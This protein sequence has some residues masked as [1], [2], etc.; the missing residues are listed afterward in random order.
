MRRSVLYSRE[1]AHFLS[2]RE[3]Q[4]TPHERQKVDVILSQLGG[5]DSIL[6]IGCGS[7]QILKEVVKRVRYVVGV[8]ESADRLQD[9]ARVCRGAELIRA[10]ANELDFRERFDAVI[11]SQM[12]HEVKM[13]GRPEE[14]NEILLVI[15]RALKPEGRYLLLDHLDPGEGSVRIRVPGDTEALLLEFKSRFRYRPVLLRKLCEGRY[16]IN[17][18]DIQDFLTKTWSL[19]SPME[20]MEMNET[21]ASFSREEAETMVEG[22]GLSVDTF[23]PFTNIEGDFRVHHAT[24]EPPA[25]PWERKF[26]LVAVK[27]A[28]QEPPAVNGGCLHGR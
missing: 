19:N 18:R 11:T 17:K 4:W 21:H 22:I 9:A 23:I 14:M 6:E 1:E 26:L 24:L 7:G 8:D 5:V 10:R 25:R 27:H 16:E 12:L 13:F 15:K 2:A 28:E 3:R 20:E